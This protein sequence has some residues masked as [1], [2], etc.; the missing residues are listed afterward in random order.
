MKYTLLFCIL[1]GLFSCDTCSDTDCISSPPLWFII[2]NDAGDTLTADYKFVQNELKVRFKD[3]NLGSVWEQ[4]V[5]SHRTGGHIVLGVQVFG[6]I[7]PTVFLDF[8]DQTDTITMTQSSRK[9]RCCGRIY[10]V[11]TGKVNNDASRFNLMRNN[12]SG[13]FYVL[14]VPE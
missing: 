12:S 9:T 7:N 14:R 5:F 8:H 6:R 2:V 13:S 10:G 11:K 1:I 3:V 4:D